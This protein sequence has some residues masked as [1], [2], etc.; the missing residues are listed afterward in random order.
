MNGGFFSRMKIQDLTAST[1]RI[2]GVT[3]AVKGDATGLRRGHP[4]L[5]HRPLHCAVNCCFDSIPK[6]SWLPSKSL[7]SKSRM[8]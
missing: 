3:L 7:T 2:H 6:H 8:P 4:N 1:A 5:L